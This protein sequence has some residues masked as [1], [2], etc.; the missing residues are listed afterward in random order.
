MDIPRIEISPPHPGHAKN[1]YEGTCLKTQGNK[2]ILKTQA[3]FRVF[4][5][6]FKNLEVEKKI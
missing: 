2:T 4:H 6:F 3:Y 1:E 5:F